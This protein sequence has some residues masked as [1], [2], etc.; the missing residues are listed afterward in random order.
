M[1]GS[2]GRKRVEP[3]PITPKRPLGRWPGHSSPGQVRVNSRWLLETQNQ[4]PCAGRGVGQTG[5]PQLQLPP[6]LCSQMKGMT[7][8]SLI[9]AELKHPTEMS[10]WP[11]DL[12]GTFRQPCI[13]CLGPQQ[14]HPPLLGAA[15]A[16]LDGCGR[17]HPPNSPS[18]RGG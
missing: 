8:S 18:C 9:Q 7:P 6:S 11:E 3:L 15:R 1:V 14:V 4:S 12:R 5:A 10:F 17:R 2:L 13:R 16:S